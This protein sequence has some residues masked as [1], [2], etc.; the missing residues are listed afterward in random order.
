MRTENILHINRV[1]LCS[2]VM[3]HLYDCFRLAHNVTH[4]SKFIFYLW[5]SIG[6]NKEKDVFVLHGELYA[7]LNVMLNAIKKGVFF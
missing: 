7:M 6:K 4:R 3:R 5:V 2:I 1:L